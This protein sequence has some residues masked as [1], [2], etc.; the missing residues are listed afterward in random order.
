MQRSEL[1]PEWVNTAI[2]FLVSAIVCVGQLP[3]L[4]D[5]HVLL[6]GLP[7]AFF[8]ICRSSL[9]PLCGFF[10]G[11]L[12]ALHVGQTRLA[13]G[14]PEH[15]AGVDLRVTG[16]V[17]ELPRVSA[18]HSRFRFRVADA[19]VAGLPE[20]IV[21]ACHRCDITFVPGDIWELTVR[22]SRPAGSV[23]PGLFDYEGWLFMQAIAATGYVRQPKSAVRVGRGSLRAMH[24]R[25]R[26]RLRD[27][28]DDLG[29][30]HAG[31]LTALAIGESSGI[32]RM[33]WQVLSRT[34]TNHLFVISG[35]H[36]GLVAGMAFKLLS[37]MSISPRS[38]SG[39]TI[40]LTGCYAA[41]AGLGLPV[42]RAFIMT[43]VVA[44]ATAM[45]RR[46]SVLTMFSTALLGVLIVE[47]FAVL[48]V[49]FWLSF[50]VVFCLLFA[51]CGRVPG[52]MGR[53]AFTLLESA[54]RTQWVATVGLLPWMLYL[55]HQVAWVSF[56][57][58]LIAIP[59]IALF[60]IPP[61]LL[62]MATMEFVPVIA[63]GACQFAAAA[64]GHAWTV[65]EWLARLD[66]VIY[67]QPLRLPVFLV[68]TAGVMFLLSPQGLVP[69]WVA[70]FCLLPLFAST[71][72]T[73]NQL[74]VTFLDVGQ[75][76]SVLVRTPT[77]VLVYDAGPG[78]SD[79]FDAGAQI[80]A[81]YLRRQSIHVINHLVISHGDNDHA[82]GARAVMR[83][84]LV[85]T[86]HA[87]YPDL[88]IVGVRCG[89]YPPWHADGLTFRLFTVD[90]LATDDNNGSCL[91]EIVGPGLSVLLTGDIEAEAEMLLLSQ[92]LF[93]ADV[94]SA[95][96]HGS[97][98]SSTPAF[99]NRLR[100]SIVV[101]STG[102]GNRFHHPDPVV[103]QRYTARHAR[104]INTATS[105]AVTVRFVRE[106]HWEIELARMLRPRF[107]AR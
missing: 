75:G 7:L 22:L 74:A 19:H 67:G 64:L 60:V 30:E 78:R 2:L 56:P 65:L 18:T 27:F 77:Q 20:L 13:A 31:L 103:V 91:L 66:P 57:V 28:I 35:L 92:K 99:L 38:V 98:S 32:E 40:I 53:S 4:P 61:I 42:Q 63:A 90:A 52:P 17:V 97:A 54:V 3:S 26:L 107:W 9:A 68:G 79:R 47:P 29:V 80:V 104:V 44:V 8:G 33:D 84:F 85:E 11:A 36:V 81:P 5:P 23:N 69:K 72:P 82:G 93:A 86:I 83:N 43:A 39:L 88:G 87:S 105:G 51:F 37:S 95:P 59:W 49:G 24:H 71:P 15:L 25:I 106:G 1:A 12:L 58:N 101:F 96:H 62:A 89:E 34:G 46:I 48:S 73:R 21:V 94:I 14:L 10:L 50:G 76:L 16:T 102:M 100:P 6:A 70:G 45:R 41:V 55:L